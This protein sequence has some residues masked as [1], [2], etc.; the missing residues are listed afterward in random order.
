MRGTIRAALKSA[1]ICEV[2]Y[3]LKGGSVAALRVGEGRVVKHGLWLSTVSKKAQ[4]ADRL[5]RGIEA[6]APIQEARPHMPANADGPA[7]YRAVVTA[8]ADHRQPAEIG[9]GTRDDELVHQLRIGIPP[10]ADRG[11]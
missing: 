10:A 3:E 5:A 9:E 4:R 6:G 7:L 1:P 11:P 2:E 8:C